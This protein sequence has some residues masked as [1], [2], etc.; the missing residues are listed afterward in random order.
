MSANQG[1]VGLSPADCSLEV[2]VDG[3]KQ[4]VTLSRE[5]TVLGSGER[6]HIRVAEVSERQAEFRVQPHGIVIANVG[7]PQ[8]VSVNGRSV[9]TE[10]PLQSGDRIRCGRYVFALRIASGAPSS[11]AAIAE[12]PSA[13]TAAESTG[14]SATGRVLASLVVIDLD[15]LP[16]RRQAEILDRTRRER[17][18]GGELVDEI[19]EAYGWDERREQSLIQKCYRRLGGRLAESVEGEAWLYRV[20]LFFAR[21]LGRAI[22]VLIVI[23]L[24]LASLVYLERTVGWNVYESFETLLD[25]L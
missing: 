22:F 8:S 16:K 24:L 20:K 13:A 18:S 11:V 5:V 15:L 19:L 10:V 17:W 2:D 3:N 25:S 7:D 4:V 9:L 14:L 12:S 1:R 6:C 23:V 21:S